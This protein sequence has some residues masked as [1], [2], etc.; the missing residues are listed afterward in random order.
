MLE[1]AANASGA[2]NANRAVA[3]TIADVYFFMIYL[4]GICMYAFLRK[5]AWL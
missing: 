3:L 4:P 1:S 2:A 5:L